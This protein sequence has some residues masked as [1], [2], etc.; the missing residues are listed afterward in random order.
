MQKRTLWGRILGILLVVAT[1]CIGANTAGAETS[2]STH[3]KMTDTEFSSTSNKLNC[4]ASYCAKASI[5]DMSGGAAKSA[6][7]TATFGSI[8]ADSEPLLEVI[9]DPGQS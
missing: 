5:G 1:I 2:S 8:A 7:S 6:T 4:S 9:V 3:Y